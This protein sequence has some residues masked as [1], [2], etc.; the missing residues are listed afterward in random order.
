MSNL[1]KYLFFASF[2]LVFGV[3]CDTESATPPAYADITAPRASETIY[4]GEDFTLRADV[5]SESAVLD[6]V[7][8]LQPVQGSRGTGF[9]LAVP[10]SLESG[11]GTLKAEIDTTFVITREEID[12]FGEHVL[13]IEIFLE[14][15][16]MGHSKRLPV[17]LS[18]R[19]S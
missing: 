14:G 2:L 3:G 4:L 9:R 7:L 17:H 10:P 11:Q 6:M 18:Q 5:E 19:G 15:G 16:K 13:T 8:S 1:S 12:V